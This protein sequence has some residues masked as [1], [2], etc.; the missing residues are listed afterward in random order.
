MRKLLLLLLTFLSVSLSAQLGEVVLGNYCGDDHASPSRQIQKGLQA[1]NKGDYPNA[2]V[3]IGAALRQNE[4][5]QHALY[6]RGEWAMRTGKFPIAE[7]SWKRL[8]KRCPGYKPDLLFFIATLAI[9]AG[10]PEEAERYLEQWFLRSD[11]E[12]GY[13]KEAENMLAELNLKETFLANPVPFNPQPA[14][15]LNTRWDEYLAALTPDGSSIYFTRRSKK[16][17]KYDGPGAQLRS[18]EEFSSAVSTG[19]HQ[20]MPAFE[21][22]TALE[23]PFNTQYNEGGPSIT[24]DNRFMVFTICERNPKTGAQNCDLYYTTYEYGVW[25]G[26]RPMPEGINRPES[27][28]SQPSISPNGDILYFTS[29]RKGGYGGLD[30]Y[31]STKDANGNWGVPE[32][33]GAAVNTKKNEKSPF[34][35]PDSESLYF[36]SDGHPGMGGYDLFKIQIAQGSAQW[37][38]P[39]NLGYPINTGSDEIGMMVTLDGQKAYFASNKINQS[40]GWDIY[41]FDLYEA[42][43]PEEVVLVRGQ[44]KIDQFASDEDPKVLLKNSVTGESQQLQL[45]HDDNSFT[46]VVKKEEAQ[47]VLVQVEAK[48]AAFSAAPLRLSPNFEDEGLHKNEVYIDLE[49]KDLESGE[50]YP[51]P[52]IL[53][54]TASDRLDAQSELLIAS[55]AEYLLVAPSLSVQIQGH[56]DN[57]GDAGANLDLSQRRAKR[58]AQTIIDLGVSSSRITYR[59]YGEKRPVASNDS[60]AGRAQNRRTVFV[61]TAL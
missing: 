35:H 17:N 51:I 7:G 58:V 11:R 43:Q 15:N 6:L 38:K 50:A 27:W 29:D 39:M 60:E 1:L 56:T 25:N 13:E 28:E 57:V 19:E 20:G 18:V 42:V 40:N 8:T 54:E 4:A 53:F 44:L 34:I 16:K 30:L 3:Y 22:G 2:G 10:R 14:R 31:R 26:I 59:G 48:K 12:L 41:F 23:A 33:L 46:A 52:H 55:F 37:G 61:V 32:N 45:S 36:A 24:A 49:H 47:Q 21:E 9:E 5:D